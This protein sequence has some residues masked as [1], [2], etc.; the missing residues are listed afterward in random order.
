[1]RNIKLINMSL[2]LD[3][4]KVYNVEKFFPAN[5]RDLSLGELDTDTFINLVLFMKSAEKT[6]YSTSFNHLQRFKLTICSFKFNLNYGFKYLKE[7]FSMKKP[8]NLIIFDINAKV[9]LNQ[10]QLNDL[11]ISINY[12]SVIEYK[13]NLSVKNQVNNKLS[14]NNYDLYYTKTNYKGLYAL[15]FSFRC[16]NNNAFKRILSNEIHKKKVITLISN[17]NK[18]QQRKK[19]TLNLFES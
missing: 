18:I 9:P 10:L 15:L 17:F 6:N 3:F 16:I 4:N 2:N 1:M 7:F 5:I 8:P 14:I 12:D 11:I 13:L 19:I